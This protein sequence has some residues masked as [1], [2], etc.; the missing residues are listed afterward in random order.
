[1]VTPP[2]LRQR[3]R[4]AMRLL[5]LIDRQGSMAPYHAYTDY[6]VKAIRDAGRIDDVQAVYFHDLPGTLPDKAALD[7]LGDMFRPDV[8]EILEIIAP[9]RDG[10]VYDD[11]AL[12]VPRPL[13]QIVD[14]LG[15]ETAVL[16]ISD[17]G[18]SRGQFDIIRLLD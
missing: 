12:A 8:D 14:G 2:T 4:N 6:V 13:E 1:V 7:E 17:A 11:T 16:I 18:A 9:L 15:T 5:M 3:R 10:I